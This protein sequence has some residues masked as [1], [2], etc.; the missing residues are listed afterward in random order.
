MRAAKAAKEDIVGLIVALENYM[1][2]DHE[3]DIA[4]WRAQAEWMLQR[5]TDFRGVA[6]SYV[7]DGREHPVPRVELVFELESG[8]D[9]HELVVALEEHDPRVFLFEPTGPSAKPNSIVINTQTMQPGEEQLVV[10]ALREVI[11]AR[12]RRRAEPVAVLNV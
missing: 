6:A 1:Q 10:E 3:A 4:S 7:H 11:G 5:L 8:I 9:A 2:R 12:L